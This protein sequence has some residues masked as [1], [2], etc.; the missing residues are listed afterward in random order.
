MTA[1]SASPAARDARPSTGAVEVAAEVQGVAQRA[2]AV[3]GGGRV[4][5]RR[6]DRQRE[7]GLPLRPVEVAALPQCVC[8]VA[9]Q[10]RG[11]R[12]RRTVPGAP[13]GLLEE[14]DEVDPAAQVAQL[15]DGDRQPQELVGRPV[16]AVP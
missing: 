12:M 15:G 2:V 5:A 3:A 1:T 6:R 11:Q 16:V 4:P 14:Q 9:E 8:V 13:Q 7:L 10:P